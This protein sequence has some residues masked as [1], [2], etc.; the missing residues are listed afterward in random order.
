MVWILILCAIIVAGILT[1]ILDRSYHEIAGDIG[2]LIAMCS[3]VVLVVLT[4]VIIVIHSP[5]QMDIDKSATLAEREALEYQL[6]EHIYLGDAGGEFNS[7]LITAQ[8]EY[9][10]PWTNWFHAG[11]VMEIEPITFVGDA[12]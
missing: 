8:K 11:W 10:S 2:K 7:E 3:G 6:H 1:K 9:Q 4:I 5:T 12:E